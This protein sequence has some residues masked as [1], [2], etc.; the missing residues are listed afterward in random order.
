MSNTMYNVQQTTTEK[1]KKKKKQSWV[2]FP[3]FF[4]VGYVCILSKIL[5]LL[6]E[7][8]KYGQDHEVTTNVN[9]NGRKQN[10]DDFIADRSK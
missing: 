7:H 6:L 8:E 1:K 10:I 2:I 4:V 3:R 5:S 9:N